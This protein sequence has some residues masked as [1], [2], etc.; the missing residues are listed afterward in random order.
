MSGKVLAEETKKVNKVSRCKSFCRVTYV[1]DIIL[2]GCVIPRARPDAVA[3]A[4]H[5]TF[6]ND[7]WD[8]S[9]IEAHLATNAMWDKCATP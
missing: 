1:P 4:K 8:I 9:Q 5:A 6:Q 7:I 2:K 3:R